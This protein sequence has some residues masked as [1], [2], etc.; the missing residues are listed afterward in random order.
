MGFDRSISSF[1]GDMLL[2][3]VLSRK[4]IINFGELSFIL[5]INVIKEVSPHQ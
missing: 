2:V 5:S 4:N 3:L 1:E